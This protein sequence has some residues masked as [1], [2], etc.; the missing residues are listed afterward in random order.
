MSRDGP[1]MEHWR[2]AGFVDTRSASL[3]ALSNIPYLK[4]QIKLSRVIENMMNTV[5]SP[6]T[7]T[8]FATLDYQ[9][10]KLNL[11]LA[12]WK[13]NLPLDMRSHNFETVPVPGYTTLQ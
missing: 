10:D 9:L 5:Y 13:Q 7:D 3:G 2:P 8:D 6:R 12:K 1:Q 4:A 11:D